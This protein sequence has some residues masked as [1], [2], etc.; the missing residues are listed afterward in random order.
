MEQE[1]WPGRSGP[2]SVRAVQAE[3]PTAEA[4]DVHLGTQL[5]A[6]LS[7]ARWMPF[8]TAVAMGWGRSA[9]LLLRPDVGQWAVLRRLESVGAT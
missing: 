2:Q 4:M 3:R 7:A 9:N 1:S 8:Q 5:R 6:G